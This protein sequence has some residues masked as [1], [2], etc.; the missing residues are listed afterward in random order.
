MKKKVV[1]IDKICYAIHKQKEG[2]DI[3]YLQ[4]VKHYE[5]GKTYNECVFLTK[6]D[7]QSFANKFG[8]IDEK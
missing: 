8:E 5:S 7:Y 1:I 3:Y 4:V 2:K 6:N